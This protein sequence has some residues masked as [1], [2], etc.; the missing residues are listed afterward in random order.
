MNITQAIS[1]VT[2]IDV[3]MSPVSCRGIQWSEIVKTAVVKRA[4]IRSQYNQAPHLTQDTN[5]KVTTSQLDC[6]TNE[7][8]K[9]IS[10]SQQV[11]TRPQL[12]QAGP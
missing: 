8:Q 12:R 11:T 2:L 6:I 4:K 10:L 1:H 9:V 7:S 3:T 5:G